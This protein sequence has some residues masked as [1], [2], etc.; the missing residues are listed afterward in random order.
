MWCD[1]RSVDKRYLREIL[2][3]LAAYMI[4][5]FTVWPLVDTTESIGL[6]VM[7]AL[8][9]VV[10]VLFGIRALVRYILDADEL[11]Q[12]LH[13][14]ALAISAGV[15]GVVSMAVGFLAAAKLIELDG[16]I[17]FWVFPALAGTFGF[18]RSLAA[19][20]YARA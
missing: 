18:A 12:R 15:V 9:P 4:I 16:S 20:R 2:M 19:R 5:M 1:M 14:E 7:I 11:V 17:L 10:P 6:R 3:A 8:I 13:L